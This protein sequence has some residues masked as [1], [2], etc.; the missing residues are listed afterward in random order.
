MK[1]LCASP[2]ATDQCLFGYTNTIACLFGLL[3][4]R[5]ISFDYQAVR[6]SD[7]VLNRNVIAHK[8]I[9]NS[10]ATHLL[11]LDTDM[12]IEMRV[13]EHFLKTGHDFM[14]AVYSRRKLDLAAFHAHARAGKD[15]ETAKALA[16][17]FPVRL[18]KGKFTFANAFAPVEGIG[19]GCVLIARRVFEEVAR[20]GHAPVVTDDLATLFGIG[21]KYRDYFGLLPNGDGSHLSEDYSFCKRVVD[22]TGVDIM[23][24]IG[25]GVHHLGQFQFSGAFQSVLVDAMEKD[26]AS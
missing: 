3:A 7:V 11:M 1:I 24:Y 9:E 21:D 14:G 26:S 16:S 15:V 8:F 4:A 6:S 19:M 10:D 25:P 12:E 18:P 22:T 2:F 23:G 13:F 20:Q 17:N 5:N